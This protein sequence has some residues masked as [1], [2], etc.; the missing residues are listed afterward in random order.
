M[1]LPELQRIRRERREDVR[2]WG[3]GHGGRMGSP[4]P[5]YGTRSGG[6]PQPSIV[7]PAPIGETITAIRNE[8]TFP[9]EGALVEWAATKPGLV[10]AGFFA[11]D[12][13]TDTLTIPL[14]GYW[15]LDV[16]F[17]WT[18]WVR[19]GR[20]QVL[21]DG[22]VVWDV[23][24]EFGSRF[25]RTFALD[26]L[27]PGQQ[28]TVRLSPDGGAVPP[29]GQE[30]SGLVGSLVLVDAPRQNAVD[31]PTFTVPDTA[32]ASTGDRLASSGAVTAVAPAGLEVGDWMFGSLLHNSTFEFSA[33]T[34]TLDSQG[35][36][37]LASY[38]AP[39]NLSAKYQAHVFAKQADA[40]DV[41]QSR[42]YGWS[43]S[44]QIAMSV[45]LFGFPGSSG[46]TL[47]DHTVQTAVGNVEGLTVAAPAGGFAVVLG[48]SRVTR[49][50][51]APGIDVELAA[52]VEPFGKFKASFST[53]GTHVCGVGPAGQNLSATLSGATANK[54]SYLF[55]IG[56]TG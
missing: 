42:T 25:A 55:A 40:A 15:R 18:S 8:Q 52:P 37:Y 7:V 28:V 13:P 48:G 54:Y 36:T 16:A 11:F 1:N 21:I 33:V 41:A 49:A 53:G 56:V 20:V 9:P 3:A 43:T 4:S 17:E 31:A 47:G 39:Q 32:T 45:A 26:I 29:V 30:A 44:G 27:R 34:T 38:P 10:R 46:W 23:V 6:M 2:T 12:P 14:F 24:S 51:L 22:D 5:M 19:G 50:Y 35:W